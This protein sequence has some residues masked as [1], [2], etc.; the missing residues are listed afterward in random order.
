MKIIIIP[1]II[2]SIICV[3]I[4]VSSKIKDVTYGDHMGEKIVINKD[5]LTVV[6][7]NSLFET[8]TLS[9]GIVVDRKLI[10]K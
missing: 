7:Y 4:G 6:D 2:L 5:T 9:N 8:F 3:L 1:A 10:D